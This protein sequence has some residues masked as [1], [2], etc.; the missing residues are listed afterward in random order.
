MQP[1]YAAHNEH[2]AR[3]EL[4]SVADKYPLTWPDGWPRTKSPGNSQFKSTLASALKNVQKSLE[5]FARDSGKKTTEVLISSNVSLGDQSPSDPGVAV[6]FTW[7]E[8]STCIAVDRYSKVQDNLQ[9]I[10]HVIEAER[11]KLRHG[12]L[13]LVRAAFRGYA[14]LPPPSDDVSEWWNVIGCDKDADLT[15]AKHAYRI[16]RSKAHREAEQGGGSTCLNNIL[17]AW[18]VAEAHF[19]K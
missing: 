17:A 11:T 5:M 16:A 19:K 9:A 2:Q 8:I 3:V 13:N 7:D 1:Q 15:T 6:Y 4:V 12:G 14:A 10:H 18:A